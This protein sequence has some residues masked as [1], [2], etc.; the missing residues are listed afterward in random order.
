M[1]SCI[2]FTSYSFLAILTA[3]YRSIDLLGIDVGNGR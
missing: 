2:R 1:P 3:T